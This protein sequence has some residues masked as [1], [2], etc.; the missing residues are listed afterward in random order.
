MK[1]LYR[2]ESRANATFAQDMCGEY[3]SHVLYRTTNLY[4]TEYRIIRE[5][6]KGVWIEFYDNPKKEKFVLLTARKQFACRTKQ[7]ALKS[8]IARKNK[9]IRILTAQLENAKEALRIA[10]NTK[11]SDESSDTVNRNEFTFV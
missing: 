3:T 7:E 4:L 11:V 6:P 9:Q 8:F 1:C 5:T 2:Y 10:K